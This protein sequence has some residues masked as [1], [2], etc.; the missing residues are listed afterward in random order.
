MEE[1]FSI[2]YIKNIIKL[3]N[4]FNYNS[5]AAITLFADTMDKKGITPLYFFCKE[6]NEKKC[7]E[8]LDISDCL[9]NEDLHPL[10]EATYQRLNNI[11]WKLI[12]KNL[13]PKNISVLEQCFYNCMNKKMEVLAI[14]LLNYSQKNKLIIYSNTQENPI[15]RCIK[16]DLTNLIPHLLTDYDLIDKIFNNVNLLDYSTKYNNYM[17]F[18]YLS[19]N[20]KI[21]HQRINN[22]TFY[23]LLLSNN[24]MFL[25]E[26]IM[27]LIN[28]NSDYSNMI[29]NFLDKYHYELHSNNMKATLKL[30]NSFNSG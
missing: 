14:N 2:D 12:E 28:K 21:I 4:K 5:I 25:S 8:L 22:K 9:I 11:S 27:H 24:D 3:Q 15:F 17:I 13:I 29:F 7:L 30:K 20:N 19:D 1:T 10:E 23:N 18:K 16:K 6:R 26:L